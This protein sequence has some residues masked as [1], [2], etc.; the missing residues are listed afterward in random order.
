V[1]GVPDGLLGSFSLIRTCGG[2][3]GPVG[4]GLWVC[5]VE[6]KWFRWNTLEAWYAV[7]S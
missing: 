2:D 5:W 4:S 6:R 3:R 1:V 7:G